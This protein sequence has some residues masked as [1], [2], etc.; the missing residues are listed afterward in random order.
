MV[1]ME[2]SALQPQLDAIERRQSY[3]LSLLVVGYLFAGIWILIDTVP[4][5]TVW[6]AGFGLIVLTILAV[7]VGI[8]RRRQVS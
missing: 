4:T 6:N 8:Y 3:I 5:V 7:M 1:C 2:E